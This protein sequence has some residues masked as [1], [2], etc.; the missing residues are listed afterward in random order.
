MDTPEYDD[1][2]ITVDL[3]EMI[4]YPQLEYFDIVDRTKYEGLSFSFDQ[5]K[6]CYYVFH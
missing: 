4:T 3:I 5:D 2:D 6:V 1:I